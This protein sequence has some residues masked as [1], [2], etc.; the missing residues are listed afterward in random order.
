MGHFLNFTQTYFHAN[1][2]LLR[3]H[4]L[5][6]IYASHDDYLSS[7]YLSRSDNWSIWTLSV[8]S[9]A[10]STSSSDCM[11]STPLQ[12]L[13]DRVRC[14]LL[15]CPYAKVGFSFCF[16]LRIGWTMSRRF[17]VNRNSCLKKGFNHIFNLASSGLM[18]N[19]LYN[20]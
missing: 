15:I 5:R 14:E 16:S 17:C 12:N 2:Y 19:V 10:S 9:W 7:I 18:K 6:E 11:F 20:I 1:G 13:C 3:S 4:Q 8:F